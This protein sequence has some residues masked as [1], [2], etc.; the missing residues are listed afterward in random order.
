VNFGLTQGN[1][2]VIGYLSARDIANGVYIDAEARESRSGEGESLV[3]LISG[4]GWL[5]RNSKNFV[6]RSFRVE[7]ITD[8]LSHACFYKSQSISLSFIGLMLLLT[9]SCLP[10]FIFHRSVRARY[11]A[12]FR[13]RP[14]GSPCN[15][16]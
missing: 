11:W 16:A 15:W 5:V 9:I 14:L 3:Q 6:D 12:R 7:G 13:H 2:F 4:V 1:H 10:I 8:L